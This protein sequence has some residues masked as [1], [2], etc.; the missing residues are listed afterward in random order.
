M[1][2]PSHLEAFLRSKAGGP[3]QGE[4]E[5]DWQ[6]RKDNWVRNISELYGVV[7]K[8]LEPLE[9]EGVLH[10]LSSRIR[11][12]EEQIGDYE[13]EVLTILIGKQKVSFYPKG[14]LIIGAEGRVDIRGQAAVRTII[15]ND[16]RWQIVERSPKLKVLPF[17]QDSFQD[18]LSEVMA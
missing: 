18:V 9:K 1:S 14:A 3:A 17:D 13:V 7:R 15:F 12:Q 10:F 5:I 8:W 16:G 2:K 11:L 6:A 4:P